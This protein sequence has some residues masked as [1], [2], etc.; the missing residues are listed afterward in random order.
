VA[1]P[2]ALELQDGPTD[3]SEWM[4]PSPV[5]V[6]RELGLEAIEAFEGTGVALLQSPEERADWL[7]EEAARRD[8]AARRRGPRFKRDPGEMGATDIGLGG[9]V[10]VVTVVEGEPV[11]PERDLL[12]WI[13]DRAQAVRDAGRRG[14][15]TDRRDTRGR[16]FANRERPS[17]VGRYRGSCKVTPQMLNVEFGG[18]DP[19]PDIA[20]AY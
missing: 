9:E 5:T 12:D 6:V 7:A 4:T 1:E 10:P 14:T 17:F 8:A 19:D 16:S 11:V 20:A 15:W 2:G 18:L 3:G 13:Q